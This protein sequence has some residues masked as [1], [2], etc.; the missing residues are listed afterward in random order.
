[1]SAKESLA[2]SSVFRTLRVLE[3]WEGGE[4]FGREEHLAPKYQHDFFLTVVDPWNSE[5]QCFE[6]WIPAAILV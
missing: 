3:T 2:A 6:C 4:M 1:M 5:R